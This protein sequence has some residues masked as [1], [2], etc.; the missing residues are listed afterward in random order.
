MTQPEWQSDAELFHIMKQECYTPVLGGDIG[1]DGPSRSFSSQPIQPMTTD[2]VLVGRAM[3][4]L[5][6]DVFEEPEKPFGLLTEALD[7]LEP[8]EIWIGSGCAPRSAMWGEILTAT[9]R[10]RGATGAVVDGFHRDTPQC[11]GTE[12]AGIQPGP[13]RS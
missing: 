6:A 12:L 10:S 1:P 2:M 13:L 11:A 3:P 8:G 7:Q 4:V 5:Y 9:A